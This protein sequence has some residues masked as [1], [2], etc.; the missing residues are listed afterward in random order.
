[1]NEGLNKVN[2]AELPI[3]EKEPENDLDSYFKNISLEYEKQEKLIEILA[4]TYTKEDYY[5]EYK[6]C[7]VD[8][9]KP[10]KRRIKFDAPKA[11][12]FKFHNQDEITEILNKEIDQALN[13][14]DLL[15]LVI[16]STCGTGKSHTI[17]DKAKNRSDLNILTNNTFDRD[18][19]YQE[20]QEN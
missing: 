13:S 17:K 14:K 3:P 20:L 9:Y 18:S 2:I 5:R 8:P 4:N 15:T 11:I 6:K 16:N 1:I 12:D 7:I 10:E 19:Y